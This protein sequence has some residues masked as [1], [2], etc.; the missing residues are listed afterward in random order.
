MNTISAING[1]VQGVLAQ[2]A[3]GVYSGGVPIGNPA[4]ASL[5]GNVLQGTTGFSPTDFLVDNNP[6]DRRTVN[7]DFEPTY[8]AEEEMFQLQITHDA[9]DLTY[10][11][12]T[13]YTETAYSSTEDYEKGVDDR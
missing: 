12:S 7:M 4:N 8:F 5:I 3:L 2:A 10:S 11:W 1:G 6:D 13:G 9:G